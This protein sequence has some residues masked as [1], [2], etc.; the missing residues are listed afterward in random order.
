MK[1]SK[2]KYMEWL[3]WM[4]KEESEKE[5]N[6]FQ[7][8][9]DKLKG[10]LHKGRKEAFFEAQQ[11]FTGEGPIYVCNHPKQPWPDLAKCKYASMIKEKFIE[12]LKEKHDLEYTDDAHIEEFH[13][14][15][16]KDA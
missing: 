15:K 11:M 12:H 13:K 16:M 5:Y 14:F 2:S 10:N 4:V 9:L 3:Q 7:K 6:F 1:F 8:I